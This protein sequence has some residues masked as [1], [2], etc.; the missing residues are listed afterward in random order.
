MVTDQ[1]ASTFTV[2]CVQMC[3][4]RDVLLN[5]EAAEALITEAARSGAEFIGTPEMTSII[6]QD[7]QKL[8]A[9]LTAPEEDIALARLSARARELS[10]WLLIGS[11]PVKVG[12]K[13]ANRSFLI[14]PQGEVAAWY[15]KIHMFDVDLANGESY[16][17]SNSFEPG[18]R[19]VVTDL[20][21]ATLGMTVCYDLR[22]PHLYRS[23]AEQGASVLTVPAAFTRQTGEA[24][25]HILLRAR[26][27]E[28]GAFVIAP[29][30]GGTHDSGRETYGHSLIV[31]PWGDVLAE[32][33]TEPGV[34]LAEVDMAAVRQ[35]RGRV[36]SLTH[37]RRFSVAEDSRGK[38]KVAS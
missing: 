24:H 31:S 32:A 17:E 9:S 25:W 4:G 6:E 13:A 1:T 23:L 28:N 35:A 27:I 14:N 8:L 37:G 26:A 2:A 20:P 15:D 21:W 30:Q 3:S 34:I 29:A 38:L 7:K 36:P 5:I 12:A 33:G 10:I 16:R 18:D 22:F 11:L 19:A